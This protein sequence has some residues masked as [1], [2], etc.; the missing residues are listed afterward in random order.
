MTALERQVRTLATAVER[1]TKQNHDLEEQLKQKN[2]TPNNQGADQEGTSA[3]RRNQEGPQASNTPSKPERQNISIPSLAETTPPL[4]IAEM[5]AMKEQMEIMMNALKGRV[6]SDLNDLV[7]R[8]DS[9]FTAT[10]NSYHLQ[11][12]QQM[13]IDRERLIPTNALLVGFDGSRVFPLGVVTLSVI[14]GDYPQQIARD[15]TFL[16]VDCS[17]A[18]NA[19]LGRPTLNSWKAALSIEEHRTVTEP[20]EKLEEIPL[21]SSDPGRTTKIG[22][23]ANPTVRQ[24]LITFLRC[25]RDVFAWGHEDML[26]IDPLVMVHRLNVS[27]AFPP[28]RQKKRV[29]APE[30]DRAMAEEVRKLQEA[31]FIREIY[32]PD[33]LANVV[34]VK[35]VSR[36]WQMC[37]DFTDLNKAYPKDSYPLPRVDVLVDFTAQHQLLSFM[38]AFSGYNQIQMH[39]VDQE[40]T[41][42]VTSQGLFCYKVM[43]FGLKNAGITYQRLMNKMFAQQIRR[44]V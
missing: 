11:M 19:I 8:T 3:D 7:N 25:N 41:S 36:K 26:G 9:P 37:M 16:V 42:F 18:Y 23:L 5:Q 1:L 22:T 24:E 12:F 27:P 33:C 4:V 32:Y 39:E 6:S 30:R 14:V 10:V 13:R 29:F 15:V 31:S 21:D 17:S 44:N 28:I 2:A 38:D 35:K 40:K 34:M 20:I 43:P